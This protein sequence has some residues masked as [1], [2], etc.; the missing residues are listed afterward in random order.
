MISFVL[1]SL[2]L[3]VW[4]N[5]GIIQIIHLGYSDYLAFASFARRL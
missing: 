1:F 3:F 4:V 2:L 5:L